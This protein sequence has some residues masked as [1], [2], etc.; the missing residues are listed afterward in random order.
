M[1]LFIPQGQGGENYSG[2]RGGGGV[3][4]HWFARE[5]PEASPMPPWINPCQGCKMIM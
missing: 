1:I 3:K 2:G 5:W 4:V